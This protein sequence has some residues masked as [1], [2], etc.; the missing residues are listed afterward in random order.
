MSAIVPGEILLKYSTTSG[1]A[2]NTTTGAP[3]TSLGKYISSTQWVGGGSNDLFDDISA[4]EN[5]AS[6][7]DYRCV[8]VHNTNAANAMQNTVAYLSAEVA[9]GAS[10]AI[11]VDTTAASALGSAAAQALSIANETTAPVGVTFSSPTS[12]GAGI[13]LGSIAVGQVRA[14]WVRR[15]AANTSAL[16]NDGVTIAVQCDTGSL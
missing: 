7:V 5:A 4:A 10:I 6:T 13:P 14:F 8:F 9:G 15:T 11:G 1:S 3:T 16:S 12:A 2:G